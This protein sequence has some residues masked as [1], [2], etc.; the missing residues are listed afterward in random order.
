M[1]AGQRFDLLAAVLPD[2]AGRQ[3][4]ASHDA[5]EA[6][7][8]VRGWHGAGLNEA[9]WAK[10]VGRSCCARLGCGPIPRWSVRTW[11]I[12]TDSGLLAKAAG[13]LARAARWLQAVGG[14]SG[15]VMTDRRWSAARRVQEIAAKLRARSKLGREDITAA[16]AR[17]DR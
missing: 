14:A 15:T 2:S 1:R 12:P 17:G 16:I 3:G 8:P 11:P 6:D 7:H 5:D 13:K 4:A 10:A 9:L